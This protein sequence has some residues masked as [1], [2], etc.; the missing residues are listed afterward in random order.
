MQ[1]TYSRYD[2]NT[3]GDGAAPYGDNEGIDVTYKPVPGGPFDS[4]IA[5]NDHT[6]ARYTVELT[7]AHGTITLTRSADGKDASFS[8]GGGL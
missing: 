4:E 3:D 2:L 5:A 1:G 7:V 8:E 6:K